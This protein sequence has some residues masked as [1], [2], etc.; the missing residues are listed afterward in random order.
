VTTP[1]VKL[2]FKVKSL[3]R[4]KA[5]GPNPSSEQIERILTK[6][7]KLFSKKII[8]L[9]SDLL[10]GVN[11]GWNVKQKEWTRRIKTGEL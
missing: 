2:Q 1:W 6:V 4:L 5:L 9:I 8:K 7:S 10:L 11:G 3:D